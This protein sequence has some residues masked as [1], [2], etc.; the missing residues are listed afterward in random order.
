LP[1]GRGDFHFDF[2]AENCFAHKSYMGTSR[3]PAQLHID[4]IYLRKMKAAYITFVL[5]GEC[6]VSFSDQSD[7]NV[8]SRPSF[9]D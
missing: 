8:D 6:P 1:A 9:T 2:Y 3:C 7:Y 5:A 4:Y